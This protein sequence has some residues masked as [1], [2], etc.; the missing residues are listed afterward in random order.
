MTSDPGLWVCRLKV[1]NRY[2]S[3]CLICAFAARWILPVSRFV[4]GSCDFVTVIP[5]DCPLPNP[6]SDCCEALRMN[7]RGLSVLPG[8]GGFAPQ[9]SLLGCRLI[10]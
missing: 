6:P 7:W 2:A 3:G 1:R 10:G 8:P 4:M 5:M 9:G